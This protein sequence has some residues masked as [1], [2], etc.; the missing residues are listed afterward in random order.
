M[1]GMMDLFTLLCPHLA[2]DAYEIFGGV[3]VD[4]GSGRR[5]FASFARHLL[6]LTSV[7]HTCIQSLKTGIFMMI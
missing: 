7:V 3:H 1:H 2:A 4:S 5:A 6:Y